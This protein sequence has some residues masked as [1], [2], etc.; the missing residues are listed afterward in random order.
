MNPSFA[1]CS[2]RSLSKH[3]SKGNLRD[4]H[5]FNFKTLTY[6]FFQRGTSPVIS[7]ESITQVVRSKILSALFTILIYYNHYTAYPQLPGNNF[8]IRF[9]K[10]CTAGL[11]SCLCY[12]LVHSLSTLS[13]ITTSNSLNSYT[14]LFL[15]ID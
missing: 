3:G 9:R 12:V 6:S 7:L 10:T 8:T 2:Q 1:R 5:N 11:W 15:A 14:I 13:T 4:H